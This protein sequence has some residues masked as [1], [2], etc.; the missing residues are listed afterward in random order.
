MQP[1][2]KKSFKF[3]R[4][5]VTACTFIFLGNNRYYMMTVSLGCKTC[6]INIFKRNALLFRSL[7]NLLGMLREFYNTKALFVCNLL[8][9]YLFSL[10]Y[11]SELGLCSI[12]SWIIASTIFL[13]NFFQ[14]FQNQ[15]IP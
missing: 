3:T 11:F 9:P 4:F 6:K 1:N 12:W 15:R 10:R 2:Q 14:Q 5:E 7:A 13:P 8:R